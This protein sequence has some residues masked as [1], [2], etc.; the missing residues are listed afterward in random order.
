MSCRS[1]QILVHAVQLR[2]VPAE[3]L[4]S[5][6][7]WLCCNETHSNLLSTRS[8]I[9]LC[10][11]IRGAYQIFDSCWQRARLA[12]AEHDFLLRSKPKE[13]PL[14]LLDWMKTCNNA[15]TE[16][17]S[18]RCRFFFN[19]YIKQRDLFFAS[20]I[21]SIRLSLDTDAKKML[22]AFPSAQGD[23]LFWLTYS[24]K[25]RNYSVYNYRELIKLPCIHIWANKDWNDLLATFFWLATRIMDELFQLCQQLYFCLND[26]YEL[27]GP[28]LFSIALGSCG[29]PVRCITDTD[30]GGGR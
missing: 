29:Y 10:A 9:W 27:Y 14:L 23:V 8:L 15:A 5:F 26:M 25:H 13:G 18:V 21:T 7:H 24:P 11:D 30:D 12:L 28:L 4:L 16:T 3:Y 19:I 6:C 20:I 1:I 2:N 17:N 22:Y